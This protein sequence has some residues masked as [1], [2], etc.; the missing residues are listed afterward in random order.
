[1]LS[2]LLLLP[3]TASPFFHAQLF[4]LKLAVCLECFHLPCL[5]LHVCVLSLLLPPA[6]PFSLPPPSTCLS[7]LSAS[8]LSLSYTVSFLLKCGS[9]SNP[10]DD[11]LQIIKR[12][13]CITVTVFV[14][15]MCVYGHLLT[16]LC[17]HIINCNQIPLICR[18]CDL[19]A[20]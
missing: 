17:V 8:S 18:L 4:S 1:M 15:C 6:S 16:F 10:L 3:T 7:L 11:R 2:L 5:A 20:R 14:V 9:P 12:V 19:I 13:V